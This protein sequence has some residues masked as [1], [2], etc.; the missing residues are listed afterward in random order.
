MVHDDIEG[1]ICIAGLMTST[2]RQ[3]TVAQREPELDEDGDMLEGSGHRH[4]SWL[5]VYL[6]QVDG[7]LNKRKSVPFRPFRHWT[8]SPL[9][10]NAI[11]T[12]LL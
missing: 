4:D 5:G 9:I 10:N 11:S 12:T 6:Q 7:R 1:E 3:R 8:W 2:R